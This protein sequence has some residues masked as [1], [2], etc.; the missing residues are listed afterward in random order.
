MQPVGAA[1]SRS[2]VPPCMGN[3]ACTM[4]PTG[5]RE[6]TG[7]PSDGVGLGALQSLAGTHLEL[8]MVGSPTDTAQALPV[9]QDALV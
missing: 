9:V 6:P 5:W 4:Q 8:L 1:E 7:T 3:W 2:M